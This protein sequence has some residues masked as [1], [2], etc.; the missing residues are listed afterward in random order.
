MKKLL[1]VTLIAILSLAFVGCQGNKQSAESAER[2]Q[3]DSL[4]QVISQ[5]D[6]EIND[7]MG[8]LNEIQT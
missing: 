5:K 8:T 6:N 3:T 4:R 2:A 1:S 7:M